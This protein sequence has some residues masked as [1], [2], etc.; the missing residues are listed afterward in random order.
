MDYKIYLVKK[1]SLWDGKQNKKC[2]RAVLRLTYLHSF[3]ALLMGNSDRVYLLQEPCAEKCSAPVALGACQE[4]AFR[5]RA[6]HS[7]LFGTKH[8]V[9]LSKGIA[10]LGQ[11]WGRAMPL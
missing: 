8:L 11:A 6:F 7:K 4:T 5:W 3:L 10:A 2:S 9:S 1:K